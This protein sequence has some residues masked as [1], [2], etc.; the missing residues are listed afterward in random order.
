MPP[1]LISRWMLWH[2]LAVKQNRAGGYLSRPPLLSQD[3]SARLALLHFPA[4]T[5]ISCESYGPRTLF[6][7]YGCIRYRTSVKN[8]KRHS[9]KYE[10]AEALPFRPL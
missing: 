2:W 5:E 6:Q 4:L 3:A 10:V 7:R 9:T 8:E 1:L